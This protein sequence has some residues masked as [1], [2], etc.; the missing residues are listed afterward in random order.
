MAG[1]IAYDTSFKSLAVLYSSG[2]LS[3]AGKKQALALGNAYVAA[4]NQAVDNLLLGKD[5]G[6]SAVESALAAF[7]AYANQV[8]REA[9]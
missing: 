2:K 5:P 1:K 8:Q 9:K 4:H 3:E 7:L 6:L